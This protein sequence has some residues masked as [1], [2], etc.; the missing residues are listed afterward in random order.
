M[1]TSNGLNRGEI[2]VSAF[3][4]LGDK[5]LGELDDIPGG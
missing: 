4:H 3:A 2:I 5:V 1:V